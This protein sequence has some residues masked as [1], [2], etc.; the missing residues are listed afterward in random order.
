MHP[1]LSRS[2]KALI[3]PPAYRALRRRRIHQEIA[4]FAPRVVEHRYAG[5]PLRITLRDPLAE[6]WYDH[7]WDAQPEIELLRAG[8]LREGARVFDIGAHQA[9]VALLLC[10]A[11]GPDGSV[12]AVEA[13][14]HNAR[15]AEEN[16]ALNDAA[17][18]T[19]VAAAISDAP[20]SLYFSEGLNGTVLPGGRTGKVKVPA[21]T[22]DGLA[23]RFGHPDVVFVDV[24]GFEGPALRGA[25]RTLERGANDFFVELHDAPTLETAG[26]S[27]KEVV[28]LLTAAGYD[29]RVAPA[30]D[31]PLSE[32]FQPLDSG[33]HLR[34]ERCYVVAFGPGTSR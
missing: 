19:V 25:S 24:E 5:L 28:G 27:A 14:P 4:S 1:L 2:A 12:V 22:I 26:T 34:G 3:P 30:E 6:G 23:K 11:V 13:E 31:G 9:V 18:L 33:V 7:D 15:V 32:D 21:V 16:G 17:N 10:D 29:C 20:G 8:R